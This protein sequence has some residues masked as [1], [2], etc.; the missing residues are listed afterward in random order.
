MASIKNK[1]LF[2]IFH[3][4]IYNATNGTTSKAYITEWN[5]IAQTTMTNIHLKKSLF[6]NSSMFIAENETSN[7]AK[8]NDCLIILKENIYVPKR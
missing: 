8:A 4:F 5:K 2:E 7:K 3:F 1:N 6:R